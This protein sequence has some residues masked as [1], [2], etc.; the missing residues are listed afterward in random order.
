MATVKHRLGPSLKLAGHIKEA[1]DIR[2]EHARSAEA[3]N[4][5]RD[6]NDTSNGALLARAI[7]KGVSPHALLSEY[8]RNVAQAQ[9][10]F[11]GF[12]K[13]ITAREIIQISRMKPVKY[14]TEQKQPT[15]KSDVDKAKTE[16]TR[17][18][19]ASMHDGLVRFITNAG[20]DSQS[21]QHYVAVDIVGFAREIEAAKQQIADGKE[22]SI[23][24]IV[25]RL[26]QKKLRISCTCDRWQYVF[27]YLATIGGYNNGPAQK[28][29]PKITNERLQGCACK[30]A[31]RAAI[32]IDSGT[33]FGNYLGRHVQNALKN[34]K[35]TNL[36]AKDRDDIENK[37]RTSPTKLVTAEERAARNQRDRERRAILKAINSSKRGAVPFA[38][39]T[40]TQKRWDRMKPDAVAKEFSTMFNLP[41]KVQSALAKMLSVYRKK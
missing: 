5:V 9:K 20:V 34:V 6:L 33:S 27:S 39:Q 35:K 32:E 18:I 26:R 40:A 38:Q 19:P 24:G 23:L 37:Q 14:R 12:Q 31:I 3:A 25:R 4:L 16:I 41:A 17:C 13:G 8:R 11:V 36:K 30:H 29:Y 7:Q 21:H 2:I 1:A 28:G 15:W 22:V 10:E